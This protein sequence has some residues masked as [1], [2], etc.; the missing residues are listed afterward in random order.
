MSLDHGILN[1]S[2]ARRGD[3]DSQIDAYKRDQAREAKVVRKQAVVQRKSDKATAKVCLAL[4]LDRPELLAAKAETMRVTVKDL[5][6]Q[7]RSWSIYQ[8]KN[9]MALADKWL[10]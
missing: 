2:L 7:L 5:R 8:P 3:I 1:V 9:L 4:I 10:A 6:A